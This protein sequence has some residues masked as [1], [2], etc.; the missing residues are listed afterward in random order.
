[1]TGDLDIVPVTPD[2]W[3]DLEWLFGERGGSS[4]CWCMWWRKSATEWDADAGAGNRRDLEA[5]VARDPAPGLL[6]YRDGAPVGWVAVAPRAEYPRL[7]RSPKLGPVDDTPAWVVSCFY[8]DRR[9][10]GTAVGHALLDAAVAFACEHGA[11]AVEGIPIDTAGSATTNA[12]LFTGTL[13]MFRAAGFEEVAR[14]GG[15]PVVRR[16]CRSG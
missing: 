13:T 15:R 9:H 1:M 11:R 5:L 6:A 8:I 4:G 10:R 2:R 7:A 3:A 14:R 16:S 12:S